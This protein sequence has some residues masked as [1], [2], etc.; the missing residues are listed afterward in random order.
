[1]SCQQCG[2]NLKKPKAKFCSVQCK[3]E[4]QKGK[5]ESLNSAKHI[6]C[7]LDGK[8]FEDYLNR[9]GT[10]TRYSKVTLNKT[11]DW[12]DW[13][14][15]DV[16]LKPTWNCPYCDWKTV[17]LDNQSG[18]ITSHLEKDHE[19]SPEEH[20]KSFPDDVKLWKMFWIRHNRN[21]KI[22]ECEDNRIQCLECGEYMISITNTHLKLKH[23][24][25]K[26]EY[27]T[28]HNIDILSST[29]YRNRL[30]E[31]YYNNEN[32]L[33]SNVWRSKYEQEI[34]DILD[35]LG[36]S[37]LPNH[38]KFGF[39]LDIYLPDNNIAI[40]FNGLYFHSEYAGGKLQYYHLNKTKECEK[41]GIHLI[42]IF[43]D[44]WVNKRKI[45]ESRIK[46]LLGKT[47]TILYAR[48]CEIREVN[49]QISSKFLE[50]NH[51]QGKTSTGRVHLG[52]FHEDILISLMT[53]G[54]PRNSMGNKN[55]QENEWELQRFCNKINYSVI[56]GAS[57]LLKY[58][59]NH[60]KISKIISFADRRWT[61]TLKGSLYD[62]LGF[63]LTSL[64]DPNYWYLVEP[65]KR[66]YRFSYTKG[67]ILKIFT[68]AKSEL[69]EWENM[70]ELGFDRIWDCGS[71]KY[72][73]AYNNSN[74]EIDLTE[75]LEIP[76][77]QPVK[78]RRKRKETSRNISD[79]E[80]KICFNSYSIVGIS[81]HFKLNH[82]LSVS[83]YIEKY[84]E[85]RPSKLKHLEMLSKNGDKFKCKI[86]NEVC[87]NENHLSKHLLSQHDIKKQQYITQYVLNNIIL[88]CK[89]GCLGDCSIINQFPYY[90]EFLPGHNGKN[91]NNGMSGRNHTLESKMKMSKPR[92]K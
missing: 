91:G 63:I 24:M 66:S 72:E 35:K 73:K 45:V 40:E 8:I 81:T 92:N 1:M 10:L 50:D 6:K 38:K 31:Q 56:G 75:V 86:C 14:I 32:L 46:N 68:N 53:F 49:F 74:L 58:F 67:K 28:K 5:R 36:I 64:G 11:F 76:K 59:E 87:R 26:K 30:R 17:D 48:K 69:S 47:E 62:E 23:G 25:T 21:K 71:L 65:M 44:E 39:D 61:S 4:S 55:K 80:C 83:E 29:D 2:G 15:I 34:C 54:L 12:N 33:N 78:R 70:I 89:C 42:H 19:L 43:E 3:V 77:H 18:W 57:R 22:H 84:G 79:V 51:I 37:Y 9:S 27:R 82:G 60:Y 16:E 90:R 85:Y 13:Q 7:I 88:K 20:C 52:L 41:L